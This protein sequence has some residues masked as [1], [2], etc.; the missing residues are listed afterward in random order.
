MLKA[1]ASTESLAFGL[2]M[3][4]I[5]YARLE[6]AGICLVK[7]DQRYMAERKPA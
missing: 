4:E 5:E 7:L 6:A 3:D 2:L 1:R